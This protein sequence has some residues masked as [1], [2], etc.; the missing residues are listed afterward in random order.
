[1]THRNPF[2]SILHIVPVQGAGRSGGLSRP[3]DTLLQGRILDIGC[4][5]RLPDGWKSRGA[6]FS[7]QDEGVLLQRALGHLSIEDRSSAYVL[8]VA[9]RVARGCEL[10]HG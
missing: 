9:L 3:S 1:M 2:H 7:G 8:Q 4:H 6:D 5:D 10:E